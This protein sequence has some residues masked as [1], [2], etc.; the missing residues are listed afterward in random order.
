[1]ASLPL[2]VVRLSFIAE[3][4]NALLVLTAAA[5]ES[6]VRGRPGLLT[7]GHATPPDDCCDYLNVVVSGFRASAAGQTAGQRLVAE[8]CADVD[9]ACEVAITVARSGAPDVA[10]ASRRGSSNASL[11]SAEAKFA[12]DVLEDAVALMYRA[13]PAIPT[14]LRQ[15]LAFEWR[16]P[17][18]YTPG[19]LTPFSQGGCGGWV[20]Q[21]T[22]SLPAPPPG[23]IGQFTTVMVEAVGGD[24]GTT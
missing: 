17:P 7:I 2:P 3:V 12:E 21:G 13:T 6:T 11:I 8:R 5:L 20:C 18:S 4:A 23:P 15:L 16:Q 10:R 14:F 19:R 1:M 22:L 24:A 9:Y